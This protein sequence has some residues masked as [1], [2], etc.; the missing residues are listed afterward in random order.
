MGQFVVMACCCANKTGTRVQ[1]GVFNKLIVAYLED[2]V[3]KAL[4]RMA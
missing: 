1:G 3:K 2:V 4:N